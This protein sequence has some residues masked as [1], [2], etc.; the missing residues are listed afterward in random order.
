MSERRPEQQQQ[1]RL[2]HLTPIKLLVVLLVFYLL[3]QVQIIVLL[4][5]LAL[6]FATIIEKPLRRLENRGV[7]RA[8]GILVI[9]ATILASL[10]VLGLVFV[11]LIV[12]ESQA[13]GR[14]APDLLDQSAENWRESDNP[15]LSGSGYRLLTRLSFQ[16][17]NPPPPP[18]GVALDAVG[19]IAAVGLGIVSMFVIGFYWL[20]EKRLIRQLVLSQL[21]DNAQRRMTRIWEDVEIKVGG[22]L[23]GQLLLCLIIGVAAGLIYYILDVRFWF[24]LALLAGVMELI[25]IL[26]PWVGAIPAV[27][28]ALLDS[29]EKALILAIA[30][31]FLQLAENTILVP[32]IMKGTIGLS[33]LTVFVAVLAGGAYMGVLGA[34]LAIPIAAGLQVIIGDLIRER[35][36]QMQLA[37]AGMATSSLDWRGIF[38]QFLT[39]D[40]VSGQ[41]KRQ[42]NETGDERE[43]PEQEEPKRD[44]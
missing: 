31:A 36:R 15:I 42:Q 41:D 10:I 17:E 7:P 35:Q 27:M 32:R 29:W 34:L 33:P 20:M 5:I 9:Y 37:P 22:W 13:F 39:H 28:V 4:V 3:V 16:L 19:Q 18:G 38:G 12:Q 2:R 25:P 1:S 6:L 14:Q 24:L 44:S 21:D 11:P 43:E 30:L 26:G 40:Q 8:P 23:R